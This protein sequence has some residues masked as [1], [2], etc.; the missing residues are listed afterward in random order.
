MRRLM[1]RGD[2]IILFCDFSDKE[3]AKS[4]KDYRWNNHIKCWQYPFDVDK[5]NKMKEMWPDLEIDGGIEEKVQRL[6]ERIKVLDNIKAGKVK[7]DIDYKFKTEPYE[8][9]RICLQWL[10]EYFRD[11]FANG[12]GI[13]DDVSLGKS[14]EALDFAQWAIQ[15]GFVERVVTLVPK[16]IR[17]KW[18]NEV[19]EHTD[20][21]PVLIGGTKDKRESKLNKNGHVY[22]M[23]YTAGVIF[24]KRVK[25]LAKNQLVIV[26]EAHVLRTPQPKAQIMKLVESLES[27]YLLLLTA[28]PS[29]GHLHHLFNLLQLTGKFWRSW[30]SFKDKYMKMGGYGNYLCIG[31]KNKDDLQAKFNSISIRRLTT[32]IYDLPPKIYE[33]R[34]VQMEGDQLKAYEL[35]RDEMILAWKDV[36]EKELRERY[37]QV[38]VQL[39]RLQ[40]IADGFLSDGVKQQ[41]LKKNAKLNELDSILENMIEG[42][43]KKVVI[44][45]HF[46]PPVVFLWERY[47]EKYGAVHLY[48]KTKGEDRQEVVNKF[49]D[50]DNYKIFICQT[51]TGGVGLDLDSTKRKKIKTD[52][53]KTSTDWMERVMVF[54]R[55]SWVFSENLQA[56][57]RCS[58]TRQC[59]TLNII[60]LLAENTIDTK[61]LKYS[62]KNQA[63]GMEMQGDINKI[64]KAE[65]MD[66]LQA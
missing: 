10:V 8:H 59:G 33:D 62:K 29:Y 42:A 51:S 63:E 37:T 3:M 60:R 25:E 36:S 12:A 14:K 53:I 32:E 6:I 56:E 4:F 24:D 49:R 31:Y 34:L 7:F 39:I 55:T 58:G 38:V 45:S 47:K 46:V 30:Y 2:N 20:L 15:N 65:L 11:G 23:N 48:G 5:I 41:W 43:K 26:D 40:Q 19:L 35:M 44:M 54:W 61:I 17:G 18:E 64:S 27:K 57:G 16:T 50:D 21:V 52:V 28:T 9:Q 13:F 1:L 66:I 22:I